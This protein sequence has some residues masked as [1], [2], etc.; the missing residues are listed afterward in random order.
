MQTTS[1]SDRLF[2]VN[3]FLRKPYD[4]RA[5]FGP[6]GSDATLRRARLSS[7]VAERTALP[8]P[9]RVLTPSPALLPRALEP[10]PLQAGAGSGATLEGGGPAPALSGARRNRAAAALATSCSRFALRSMLSHRALFL[11]AIR[12]W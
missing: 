4:A 2:G 10:S 5:H 9:V 3:Y 11:S 1:C 12:A 6:P 8:R 7:F